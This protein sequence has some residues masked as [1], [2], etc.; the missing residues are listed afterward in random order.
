[1]GNNLGENLT[2]NNESITPPSSDL[3]EQVKRSI[4]LDKK[5]YQEQSLITPQPSEEK[6][7][8][9]T[10]VQRIR[11]S[12]RIRKFAIIST[13]IFSIF[14]FI[15]G[16]LFLLTITNTDVSIFKITLTGNV[17]DSI[18]KTGIEGAEIY[19]DNELKATTNKF[20]KYSIGGLNLGNANVKIKAEEYTE[21]NQE[22][23]I[24]RL[25]LYY[26]TKR[27]FEMILKEKAVVEGKL[28]SSDKEY[29]FVDDKI[30][31]D[32]ENY[33]IKTDGTFRIEGVKVGNQNLNI[34]LSK[35][36]DINN[37]IEVK[38][39]VN[40]IPDIQLTPAGDI[41]GSL[42]SYVEGNIV[43]NIK[44]NVENI[45]QEQVEINNDK[46]RIRDLEVG[47]EYTINPQAEGYNSRTYKIIIKQ[48]LNTIFDFNLVEKGKTVLFKEDKET[49]INQFFSFD[50]DGLNLVKHSNFSKESS[51]R[52]YDYY[53]DENTNLIYFTSDKDKVEGQRN[54]ALVLRVYQID[55]NDN[56]ESLITKSTD[57]NL[58]QPNFKEKKV[59]SYRL[60]GSKRDSDKIYSVNDLEGKQISEFK[61]V[62]ST[63]NASIS[64]DGNF[65]L[66]Y[67]ESEKNTQSKV[68]KFEISSKTED[69][70]VAGDNFK[71]FSLSNNANQVLFT[72]KNPSTPF[73]DLYLYNFETKEKRTVFQNPDGTSFR[74]DRNDNDKILY[75]SNKNG[76]SNLYKYSINESKEEKLTNLAGDEKITSFFTQNKNYYFQTEQNLYVININ[77]LLSYKTVL[78]F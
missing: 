49:R 52:I 36:K 7:R 73:N 66:L 76:R 5:N 47:K 13:I 14:V 60:T 18:S 9:L 4:D 75:T 67:E 30:I 2:N 12:R 40:K 43:S 10:L 64:S 55:L 72:S 65:V 56:K 50:F 69:S 33:K 16:L 74:F 37:N 46:F 8:E 26:T 78:K 41:E 21:I 15:L 29:K 11:A 31:I 20:G 63:Y 19:I 23:P 35:F 17:V 38:T 48:G 32:K 68:Y 6:P 24:N 3:P 59:L 28:I 51:N 70:F 45:S 71:F 54:N 27:D 62:P 22:I 57:K 34:Q 77:K 58:I 61:T 25:F 1:M 44:F 42:K 39:G 53:F